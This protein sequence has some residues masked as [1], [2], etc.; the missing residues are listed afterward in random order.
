[1]DNTVEPGRPP[2]GVSQRGGLS[3]PLLAYMQQLDAHICTLAADYAPENQQH[4]PLLPVAKLDAADHFSSFPHQAMFAAAA[5]PDKDNLKSFAAEPVDAAGHLNVPALDAVDCCLTPGAC[6]PIYIDQ[7]GA[8][9]EETKYITV[10]STCFRQEEQERLEPLIRQRAFTMRELVCMGTQDDVEKFLAT[11]TQRVED[12]C[13]ALDLPIVFV[14][15]TDPF[16]EPRRNKK[17]LMQK[18]APVKMEMTYQE[19]LAIGSVNDHRNGFGNTFAIL[20][21]GEPIHSGCVAF[22]LE[23]WLYCLQ[24]QHGEDPAAW[25]AI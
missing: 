5:A 15:A 19:H 4:S 25:P 6:Y 17:F 18:V 7:E 20:L 2:S 8:E 9:L 3:G 16:F 23:R 11:L 12:M 24:E 21:H 13:Q 1:M 22:G 14:Q 10:R